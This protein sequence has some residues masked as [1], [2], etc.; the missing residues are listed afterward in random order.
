[1]CLVSFQESFGYSVQ[2]KQ[3]NSVYLSCPGLSGGVSSE[4]AL[5]KILRRASA[6]SASR[7]AKDFICW[8]GRDKD[9]GFPDVP[10]FVGRFR[11]RIC[12]GGAAGRE[13]SW[14]TIAVLTGEPAEPRWDFLMRNKELT[15]SGLLWQLKD[16]LNHVCLLS[17]LIYFQFSLKS[18]FN[19]L[20]GKECFILNNDRNWFLKKKW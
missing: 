4:E 2:Y 10:L 13:S 1:M 3:V 7:W 15:E 5:P 6:Y 12:G 16:D 18:P 8:V 14:I 9:A 17:F 19:F 11:I 20:C